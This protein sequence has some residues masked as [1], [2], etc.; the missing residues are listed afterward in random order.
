MISKNHI[1]PKT[2]VT[3][4][5]LG[6]AKSH[7]DIL[8]SSYKRKLPSVA[9]FEDDCELVGRPA[10]IRTWLEGAPE[11]WDLLLL[12]ANEYVDTEAGAGA[13]G[14]YQPVQR[15]WGTHAMLVSRRAMHA[16]LKVWAEAQKEGVF[17]PADW[18]WNEA[19]RRE[20]LRC[21]GPAGGPAQFVR[22]KEGLRSAITGNLRGGA[23]GTGNQTTFV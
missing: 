23:G 22:Q 18:M 5:M 8:L 3:R 17:L 16:A 12:G 15:F 13:L 2:E 20:K 11:G 14:P 9:L 21:W 7:L 4:G 10:E 1:R 19:I 6:C